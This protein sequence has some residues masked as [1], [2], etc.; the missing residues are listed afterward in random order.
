MSK[1][2]KNADP[3]QGNFF[4]TKDVPNLTHA[5]V[6]ESIQ[7]SLDAKD[8]ASMEPIKVRFFI[9]GVKYSLSWE[10]ASEIFEGLHPHLRAENNGLQ[11]NEIPEPSGFVPFLVVEDFQ[12]R[13]LE[14]SVNEDDDPL[15]EDKDPH[16]FYWFWRNVGRS[17]KVGNERGRWGLGKTVFPASSKINTY[18]GLTVRKS[19]GKKFLMGECVLKIHKDES[20]RKIN[21][22]GYFGEFTD[23]RDLYFPIPSELSSNQSVFERLFNLERTDSNGIAQSGL[24]IVIPFPQDEISFREIVKG[25][26]VQY[27]YPI[28]SGDLHV[29]ILDGDSDEVFDIRR[30]TISEAVEKV[31]FSEEEGESKESLKRLFELAKWAIA[32]NPDDTISLSKPAIGNTPVWKKEWFLR[33]GVDEIIK[34]KIDSFDRGERVSFR[35][36]VKVHQDDLEPVMSS[37]KV[38]LEKDSKLNEAESH[39]VRAGITITGVQKPK[40]KDL[41]VLVV[42]EDA[43][44]QKLL[45]DAENPA[46]TEWQ[47]DSSH[48][49]NK[50][51]DGEKVI[52]F[53][54]AA[55]SKLYEWLM[56]PVSGVDKNILRDIFYIED[57]DS[58]AD[59]DDTG[60][61]EGG[62]D[63]PVAPRPEPDGSTAKFIIRRVQGGF[64]ISANPNSVSVPQK[65]NVQMAYLVPKGNP[66]KKYRRFDFDFRNDSMKIVKSGA[67]YVVIDS[68][69]IDLSILNA[70]F[71]VEICGFDT[72]RDIYIK[73]VSV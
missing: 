31:V 15:P 73:A 72:Q 59:T 13:G 28:L 2:E 45:G 19:D 12:T 58:Q 9:S 7:N 47:K 44:L 6:R 68:N 18:Y 21:P 24:S 49:K 25:V 3:V 55:P 69:E 46:H 38:F 10:R 48:F 34:S 67:E 27:F 63:S 40:R 61:G 33:D 53:V 71:N 42:I 51:V 11:R 52:A 22:Y 30:D 26:I 14:G 36:P 65:I 8:K 62:E 66:L 20:G 39:F 16:N 64:V 56:V 23:E 43:S 57:T 70:D 35:V 37:F 1:S 54:S 50:Y 5:L 29:E 32:I 60:E 41:R 4:T 17:G